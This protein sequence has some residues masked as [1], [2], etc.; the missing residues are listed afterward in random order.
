MMVTMVLA[1]QFAVATVRMKLYV[2]G[3][4]AGV[5]MAVL[6]DGRA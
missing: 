6:L 2:T 4:Q 1:V 5:M 3:L